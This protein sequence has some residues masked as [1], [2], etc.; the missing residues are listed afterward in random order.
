MTGQ[1]RQSRNRWHWIIPAA[2]AVS[3]AWLG[4][5]SAESVQDFYSGRT[6][7]MDIGYSVGGGYDM[8]ARLLA[9]HLGDHLPGKPTITPQNMPGAGSLKAANYL[10]SVAPK[11]GATIGTFGRTMPEEPLLGEADYDARKL[12]WLGSMDSD[13]SLCV[14]WHTSSIKTFQDLLTKP[15]RFGGQGAGSDPDVMANT[16]KNLLHA[17]LQLV[18]GYP[19]S[20]E[21]ALAMQRGEIDGE[22]G[23]SWS[24]LR[25]R[26]PD[27][28]RDHK[29]NLI[30]QMA[31]EKHPDLPNVP[32]LSDLTSDPET[33]K[34]LKVIAASQALA[35]PFA[36]PP[37]IP[38]D[39][40]DALRKAFADTMKDPAFVADAKS[41][42]VEVRYVSPQQI[43]TVLEDVYRI[44]P[45]Q[46]AKAKAAVGGRM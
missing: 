25:M 24:T 46:I 37:G 33:K 28:L 36:A 13:V 42:G 21:T 5:A 17:K 12:V 41:L 35:R 23:T 29:V 31:L 11:D 1:T 22:C 34:I 2:L 43:S 4:T 20:N 15:S 26:H 14:T 32:L 44:S 45:D 30:V 40:A 39:R 9:K 38:A 6:V 16:I 8:Y 10:Y 27:W 7:N 18:T 19:G 3:T